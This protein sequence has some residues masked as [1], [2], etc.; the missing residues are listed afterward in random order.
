MLCVLESTLSTQRKYNT[1]H[2]P[3]LS[4]SSLRLDTR[5][6][7]VVRREDE[8]EMGRNLVGVE[9]GPHDTLEV[10]AT[11]VCTSDTRQS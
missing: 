7:F 6:F 9:S 3:S 2:P 5:Q 8:D 1:V 4:P 11:D 10:R